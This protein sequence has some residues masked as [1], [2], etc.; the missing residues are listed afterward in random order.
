MTAQLEAL[1]L[2]G[3]VKVFQE[4]ASGART[5]R[6]QLAKLLASLNAGDVVLVTRLDRLAR[7]PFGPASRGAADAGNPISDTRL[8]EIAAIH[9]CMRSSSHKDRSA[10][11]ILHNEIGK[12]AGPALDAS[13]REG[14][15]AG[16]GL[17]ITNAEGQKRV[18]GQHSRVFD[19]EIIREMGLADARDQP[20][21][22][23]DN[24]QAGALAEL[25][26]TVEFVRTDMGITEGQD[27][28]LGQIHR[29]GHAVCVDVR[30]DE[31][32]RTIIARRPACRAAIIEERVEP[33]EAGRIR[34]VAGEGLEGVGQGRREGQRGERVADLGTSRPGALVDPVVPLIGKITRHPKTGQ[35]RNRVPSAVAM[36][37]GEVLP[38]L[39]EDGRHANPAGR[40]FRIGRERIQ[41]LAIGQA[42]HV[43]GAWSIEEIHPSQFGL[44]VVGGVFVRIEI[45]TLG[46]KSAVAQFANSGH[47]P[48]LT[49]SEDQRTTFKAILSPIGDEHAAANPVGLG[50]GREIGKE[51][52]TRL[53]EAQAQK[54]VFEKNTPPVVDVENVGPE[55]PSANRAEAAIEPHLRP[56]PALETE[57]GLEISLSPSKGCLEV[58]GR[59]KDLREVPEGPVLPDHLD[60]RF[61][62]QLDMPVG[63]LVPQRVLGWSLR[64]GIPKRQQDSGRGQGATNGKEA[65]HARPVSRC[66]HDALRRTV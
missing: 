40:R 36:Q 35:G 10:A 59:S 18:L 22:P 13:G 23:S 57:G 5:D 21:R 38:G 64:E 58:R 32:E 46:G 51:A 8:I 12:A 52:S 25:D 37:E 15:Q 34:V 56:D 4:K 17:G 19:K 29:Q 6:P 44:H 33:F 47:R 45:E 60:A 27:I 49:G 30:I 43:A 2:A 53:P 26:R 48:G 28:A 66:L 39:H 42:Q 11:S 3:A 65:L 31:N 63:K 50:T 7:S 1:R 14:L 24:R 62:P 16:A 61:D 55:R 41:N 9:V 54:A 20:R